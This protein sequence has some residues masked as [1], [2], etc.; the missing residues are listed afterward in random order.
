MVQCEVCHLVPKHEQKPPVPFLPLSESKSSEQT[1]V[2]AAVKCV[3]SYLQRNKTTNI[4]LNLQYKCLKSKFVNF[5]LAWSDAFKSQTVSR[6]FLW[7]RQAAMGGWGAIT[8]RLRHTSCSVS[9]L[10]RAGTASVTVEHAVFAPSLAWSRV[11]E[12]GD[13][14]T[15]PG[16]CG[17][18][19]SDWL[20]VGDVCCTVGV[21]GPGSFCL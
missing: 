4:I 10:C 13:S 8:V 20:H 17:V 7:R 16:N 12:V 11:P 18:S 2:L 15:G 6:L 3:R 19:S 21:L 5:F 14:T 9:S 1:S